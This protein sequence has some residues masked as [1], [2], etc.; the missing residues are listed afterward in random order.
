MR[1]LELAKILY[2]I[3]EYL[4]MEGVEFKPRAY[5]RAARV[6]EALKDD[7]AEIYRAGGI[8][9]LKELPDIGEG[10]ALRI[11]EFIKTG[12]IKA[13]QKLRK[14]CPV[15]L[16]ELTAVEGLGPKMIKALYKKLRIK[17]LRDLEKAA[18]QGKIRKLPHFGEK[19][20]QNILQAIEFL[21]KSKGRFLLGNVLPLVREIEAR[22]RKVPG[23]G[24]VATAGSVRR[25][26]ETIGDLDI[27]VTSAKAG[28]AMDFFVSMPEVIKIYSKGPTRSSVRLHEGIDADIRVVPEKCYGS[29]LQYFTGNK[30][31]NIATREIAIKK[32][33]KLN[34]YGVFRGKKQIAGRTEEEVYRAIG[35]PYIEPEIRNN[36]GEI[37]AAL[38]SKLPK[39]IGYKDIRGDLHVHS[40]WSDGAETIEIIARAAYQFGYE[41]VC[42]ADH[43]QYLKMTHGLDEKE[44][45]KQGREIDRLNKKMPRGFKI[46]KG[47]EVNILKNGTLDVKDEVL[48]K[49]DV[50]SAG[51]HSHFHLS[52]E[53]MTKRLIR[54]MENPN[55]DIIAHPTG[56]LIQQRE[57]Y[58]FDW[59]A[60]LKKAKETGTA[61]EINA[62]PNRLDLSD[63]NIRKA[64]AMG[65]KLV[66][67]TDAHSTNQLYYIELGIAQA[68]RGWLEKKD[69]LNTRPLEQFLKGLRY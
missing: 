40:N 28:K 26:Q 55:V 65:V 1:N 59:E 31:H 64:K 37:E 60:V 8:H 24:Q 49:L 13:Y 15:Q 39:L 27:L 5:E 45:L 52:K 25:M 35:L 29:A 46:L 30:D 11:E 41:Y 22:F 2:E 17:N 14:A 61:L 51:I 48:A 7:V 33:L 19:T 57:G 32:G 10:I 69:I 44:I 20:E 4:E 9:A 50:V 34:E 62:L 23:V 43:T 63:Q 21:K 16:D 58:Q 68:R 18:H 67:N 56:R 42:I 53:E 47:A 12:K 3:A 66:I 38:A 6:I 36:T 54:A